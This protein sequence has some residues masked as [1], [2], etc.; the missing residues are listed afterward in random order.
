MYPRVAAH[1]AVVLNKKILILNG[2]THNPLYVIR[3]GQ[4]VRLVFRRTS[5]RY[6]FR[7]GS[8]LCSKVVVY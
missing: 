8:P 1:V 3:F 2:R 6:R 5:V 4:T 7:F